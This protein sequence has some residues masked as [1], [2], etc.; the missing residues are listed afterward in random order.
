MP[1]GYTKIESYLWGRGCLTYSCY[2]H[3]SVAS[4]KVEMGLPNNGSYNFQSGYIL[5]LRGM[6][7][8]MKGDYQ[9]PPLENKLWKDLWKSKTTP[10]IKHFMW[11]AISGSLA[12]NQRLGSRG[13]LVDPICRTICHVIFTCSVALEI[14]QN[15]GTTTIWF[16]T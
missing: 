4:R 15:S 7:I 10:K 2:T 6:S 3:R 1:L 16:L 12:V 14:W 9:L 13:I 11:K 5:L 8:W